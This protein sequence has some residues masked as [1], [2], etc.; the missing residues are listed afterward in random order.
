MIRKVSILLSFILT[1]VCLAIPVSALNG[2]GQDGISGNKGNAQNLYKDGMGWRVYVADKNKIIVIPFQDIYVS[3]IMKPNSGKVYWF[4]DTK[5]ENKGLVKKQELYDFK[6]DIKVPKPGSS[7]RSLKAFWSEN[8]LKNMIIGLK[9][10]YSYDEIKEKMEAGEWFIVMEPVMYVR[11]NGINFALTATEAGYNNIA[12]GGDFVRKMGSVTHNLLP[13]WAYFNM[14]APSAWGIPIGKSFNKNGMKYQVPDASM[15]STY[16]I[17]YIDMSGKT[18]YTLDTYDYEFHT[19]TDVIVA[20][21][22][23]AGGR[24]IDPDSPG[25]VTFNFPN[26]A[27]T[28]QYVVPGGE[29]QKVWVSWHT[30]KEE[31]EHTVP[32]S[33]SGG[34]SSTGTINIKVTELEEEIPPDPEGKET[35]EGFTVPSPPKEESTRRHEW[36][37][38]E[39]EWESDIKEDADGNEYDDGEWVFTKNRF[40]AELK[41]SNVKI[42]PDDRAKTASGNNMKSGYGINA[43]MTFTV[44]CNQGTPGGGNY[45]DAQYV[46]ATFPEFG[47]EGFNRFLEQD[48]GMWQ[49][50]QNKFSQF[51]NRVHFTPVW[52]PDN[53]RYVVSVEVLDVWTPV[54]EL[55]AVVNSNEIKIDGS[56]FDDW[57]TA[58]AFGY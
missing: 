25:S 41:A 24:D 52:Y 42:V 8:N 18:E 47:Y 15:I 44:I 57:H 43:E 2:D 30:P 38:W 10:Q 34:S 23:S 12:S 53:S 51:K 55:R 28:K 58:P 36:S 6:K 16:G 21:D 56:V 39:A 4:G 7:Y 14:E 17:M 29:T 27:R 54:G 48:G 32:V 37:E 26:G 22:V 11:V 13:G 3:G 20:V 45:T 1:C 49:F 40:Y 33:I 35:N 50:K 9:W 19:D 5:I 46:I 31:G